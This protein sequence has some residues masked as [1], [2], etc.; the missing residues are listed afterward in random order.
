MAVDAARLHNRTLL[1]KVK[2][3]EADADAAESGKA[4]GLKWLYEERV[5]WLKENLHP[6]LT[7]SKGLLW[8]MLSILKITDW[9]VC[10]EDPIAFPVDG[11]VQSYAIICGQH[12]LGILRIC[13]EIGCLS[14]DMCRVFEEAV[15]PVYVTE[16]YPFLLQIDGIEKSAQS[17]Q[18]ESSAAQLVRNFWL[19]LADHGA[20][21]KE[22]VTQLNASS[23]I[24]VNCADGMTLVRNLILV[25]GFEG[26]KV[27][28]AAAVTLMSKVFN[29]FQKRF[30]ES[31]TQD[32]RNIEDCAKYLVRACGF[33][34]NA[35]GVAACFKTTPLT[36]FLEKGGELQNAYLIRVLFAA[37]SE[38]TV[39]RAEKI[40]AICFEAAY[41][42]GIVF[43]GSVR[44]KTLKQFNAAQEIAGL[45]AKHAFAFFSSELCETPLANQ[46]TM[47]HSSTEKVACNWYMSPDKELEV[48]FFTFWQSLGP[49][50]YSAKG[51]VRKISG[52]DLFAFAA[53]MCAPSKF[54]LIL[55]NLKCPV[56]IA[57]NPDDADTVALRS[58]APAFWKK[59][60]IPHYAAHLG[61]I[62][63][64]R[65]C[66]LN[67]D[68]DLKER[69]NLAKWMETMLSQGCEA[70][71]LVNTFAF[72]VLAEEKDKSAGQLR[73]WLESVC[74]GNP[75]LV[76]KLIGAIW[77][78]APLE[79]EG[80]G[81]I[82]TTP[83]SKQKAAKVPK[84]PTT[85]VLSTNE[86]TPLISTFGDWVESK[87]EQLIA[88]AK[89][90]FD[91]QKG[92]LMDLIQTNFCSDHAALGTKFPWLKYP[93]LHHGLFQLVA[94][95]GRCM[96]F[97]KVELKLIMEPWLLQAK[98]ERPRMRRHL[99]KRNEKERRRRKRRRRRRRRKKIVKVCSLRRSQIS[100]RT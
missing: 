76:E 51:A 66:M 4:E 6:A 89:L 72:Y 64:Q 94:D 74:E 12:R 19:G 57:K 29:D 84:T 99:P 63:Q 31:A 91:L 59:D 68:D 90:G 75:V 93:S 95:L 52:T 50:C 8:S 14:E 9:V 86:E 42:Y 48:R 79:P 87:W 92:Q 58:R 17:F 97:D 70:P 11:K 27:S 41:F 55:R 43:G 2:G 71:F 3:I 24:T 82:L 38:S 36:F 34:K 18:K 23:A 53:L 26:A 85:T 96:A 47:L 32:K 7:A 30:F 40:L 69:F 25:S 73:L 28:G 60:Q 45:H 65:L 5:K 46:Y 20:N 39:P 54:G 56:Y 61:E 88:F 21:G 78:S 77:I 81:E 1:Q 49:F 22:L 13:H 33:L 35:P 37:G 10:V 44:A 80:K 62:A 15:V 83:K 100:S 98:G 16:A 67:F